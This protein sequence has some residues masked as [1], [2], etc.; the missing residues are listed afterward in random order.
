[1]QIINWALLATRYTERHCLIKKLDT[2]FD[3]VKGVEKVADNAGL[4]NGNKNKL[5]RKE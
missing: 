3:E 5:N 4:I 2:I 1:M